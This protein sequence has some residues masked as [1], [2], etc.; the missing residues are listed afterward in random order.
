MY[1][2]KFGKSLA[3]LSFD[4]LDFDNMQSEVNKVI[5]ELRTI[6]RTDTQFSQTANIED[7]G[8]VGNV[9]EW[10][11]I[12]S[13]E[14]PISKI[15]R[16]DN[17]VQRDGIGVNKVIGAKLNEIENLVQGDVFRDGHGDRISEDRD[18]KDMVTNISNDDGVR[19]AIDD[20]ITNIANEDV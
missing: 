8:S 15:V 2:E 9:F 13:I 16:V 14:A 12:G 4:F 5:S 1:N 3:K 20:E 11:S 6:F 18:V 10:D 7:V 17:V 19:E